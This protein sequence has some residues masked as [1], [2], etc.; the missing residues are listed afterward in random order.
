MRLPQANYNQDNG[1]FELLVV[2]TMTDSL[3]ATKDI[4]KRI[5]NKR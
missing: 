5:I 1:N 4:T 2:I 3:G